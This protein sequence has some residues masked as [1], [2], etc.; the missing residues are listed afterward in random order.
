MRRSRTISRPSSGCSR[1]FCRD[2]APAVI[3]ADSAIA[4][5]VIA[6]ARARGPQGRHCRREGRDDP[7]ELRCARR[8]VFGA[9]SSVRRPKLSREVSS[10]RRLSDLQRAGRRRPLHRHGQRGGCGVRSV[11]NAGGRAGT[12]RA[13]RRRPRRERLRRLRAQARRAREGDRRAAAIR[14]RA[15][16]SGVRLRRRPR[17]GQA[18]DH[19]RDRRAL[20]RRDDRDRRQPALRESRGDPRADPGER[21]FG[22]RDR[23]PRGG[24]SRRR[25][26]ASRRRCAPDRRQGSRN[27]ADRWRQDAAVLRRR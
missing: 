22:D 18:A 10:G 6:A 17:S 2:G 7:P 16:R 1:I 14:A 13:H 19:G 23:R 15:S 20:G 9:R 27:G 24:H 21:A 4:P 12:P 25:R 11:A 26:D 3:D 8:T 5:R